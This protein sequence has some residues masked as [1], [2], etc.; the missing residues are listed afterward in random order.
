VG[1]TA[2]RRAKVFENDCRK[3][4]ASLAA[5]EIQGRGTAGLGA[6]EAASERIADQV[7][8][9]DEIDSVV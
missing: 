8:A 1:R 6:L 9:T 7:A 5:Q 2:R 4:E 3:L